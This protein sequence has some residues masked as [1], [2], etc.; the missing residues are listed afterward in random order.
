MTVP[1]GAFSWLKTSLD[2]MVTE[3]VRPPLLTENARRQLLERGRAPP[4]YG[5]AR[6]PMR[7]LSAATAAVSASGLI[8]A[9]SSDERF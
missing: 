3:S 4:A 2:R 6:Y 8:R 9:T 7:P 1:L 5:A